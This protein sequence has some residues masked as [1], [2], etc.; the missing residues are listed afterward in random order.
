TAGLD[1]RDR[2]ALALAREEDLD[3]RAEPRRVARRGRDLDHAPARKARALPGK[4]SSARLGR[5]RMERPN[6]RGHAIDL[7]VQKFSVNGD[8]GRAS[9]SSNV[10]IQKEKGRSFGSGPLHR[11]W[12]ELSSR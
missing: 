11:S 10:R 9:T 1:P 8:S 4:S 5:E 7:P 2:V 12:R 6:D 3:G